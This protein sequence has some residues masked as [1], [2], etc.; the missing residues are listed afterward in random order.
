MRK[1]MDGI[2][3][4][5]LLA[6]A[7]N[8]EKFEYA[9]AYGADAVYLGGSSFS[10][11]AAADNFSLDEIRSAVSLAHSN[12]KKVYVALNITA[13][14]SQIPE[15]TGYALKLHE[16][17]VDAFI[18]SDTGVMRAVK[19]EIPNARIH[20]STQANVTN[21]EAAIFY[22]E[23]GA[24]R[25]VLARELSLDEISVIRS[26]I[27]KELE[28][29][30][31]V[32]GAMCISYSGRCL[33]S[34]FMTGRDGN[35]GDCAQSC[36]WKYALV[37]EK[38]PGGY[39]PVFEDSN[40]SYILNSKDLC[41]IGYIDSLIGAGVDSFKIEGRMKSIFYTSTVVKI[42]REAIDT[43][44]NDPLSYTTDEA[45]LREL[46]TVSHREY[47]TGFINGVPTDSVNPSS[48]S[49]IRGYTFTGVVKE[50]D[51]ENMMLLVEQR[52]NFKTGEE[53]EL[54]SPGKKPEKYYVGQ[55]FDADLNA[56]AAA[57]HPQMKVYLPYNGEKV[58]PYSF[59]RR[60]SK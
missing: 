22:Y 12:G 31:F 50:H 7:G 32:H 56:I 2:K 48:S 38:R 51:E 28:L 5:E 37:E 59:F 24:S 4:V 23:Q 39:Y 16:A 26:K 13:R 1:K 20:V 60:R 33:L 49:Y 42:Y 58:S 52:N 6:P 41:L 30:V 27:P 25:I 11:R 34:S 55:I 46:D 45:W 18:I 15:M 47:T 9:V 35:Q 57:P 17:G 19:R 29:E 40:G 36:R 21:H 14:G 43:Y 53:L 3:K 10:M 8:H 44:Y 54:V